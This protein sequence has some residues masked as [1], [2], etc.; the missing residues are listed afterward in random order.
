M[1][2]NVIGIPPTD[3]ALSHTEAREGAILS[4]RD[5]AARRSTLR[6]LSKAA[7]VLLMGTAGV[8]RAPAMARA[9]NECNNYGCCCLKHPSSGSTCPYDCNLFSQYHIRSWTCPYG[10]WRYTCVECTSGPTCWD[11]NWLCSYYYRTWVC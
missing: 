8:L 9:D 7:L 11:P 10:C 6:L 4:T 1:T 5:A 3:P 2:R